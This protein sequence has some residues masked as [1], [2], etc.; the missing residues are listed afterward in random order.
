MGKF[1]EDNYIHWKK[2]I[3]SLSYTFKSEIEPILDSKLI[4][5]SENTHPKLLKEY[6][7]KRISLESMVI[8]DSI[9]GFSYVWDLRLEDDY[10]WKDVSKLMNDYKSFLKFDS[11]KFKFVLKELML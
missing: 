6:L 9:L 1:D 5:V 4:A 11:T 2:K 10:T 7:G 8:L 3:Q